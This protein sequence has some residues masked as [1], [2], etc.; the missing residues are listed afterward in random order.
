MNNSSVQFYDF[1]LSANGSQWL[2]VSGAYFRVISAAGNVTVR[3]SGGAVV[4]PINAGQ[5]MKNREFVGLL[6]QDA[7][8]A[9]NKGTIIVAGSDF[10]DDRITGEVSTIDGGKARSNAGS[11]FSAYAYQ[12][13]GTGNFAYVQLW[14]ESV[15]RVLMVNGAIL[16]TNGANGVSLAITNAAAASAQAYGRAKR[17]GMPASAA[18][19]VRIESTPTAAGLGSGGALATLL[20]NTSTQTYRPTEPIVIPPGYGLAAIGTGQGG[21]LGATFEWFEESQ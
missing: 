3:E 10:V 1:N 16:L 12:V 21:D 11:A 18:A 17:A 9:A 15:N 14:N 20:M 13:G 4:G 5:G 7:S 19:R 2:P 8:G 6:I